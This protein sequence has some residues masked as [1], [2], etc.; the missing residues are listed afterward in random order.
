MPIFTSGRSGAYPTQ[1]I[2]TLTLEEIAEALTKEP[3]KHASLT[4]GWTG[5][6]SGA[7]GLG[8]ANVA[9]PKADMVILEAGEGYPRRLH[10]RYY[11]FKVDS[12]LKSEHGT[13][14]QKIIHKLDALDLFV[15]ETGDGSNKK[16]CLFSSANDD[17]MAPAY[18]SLDELVRSEDTAAQST[19]DSSPLTFGDPDVFLWLLTRRRDD[20]KFDDLVSLMKIDRI[21]GQ[22][23]HRRLTALSKGVDFDR[24]SFLVAVADVETLGPA[25]LRVRDLG[26]DS[27]LYFDLKVNGAFAVISSQTTYRNMLDSDRVR[28]TAVQDLAYR[29]LPL[30]R[31]TY[32]KDQEWRDTG[33]D[34]EFLKAAKA[35]IDLYTAKYGPRL[36]SLASAAEESL[37]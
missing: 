26:A 24:P 22:D 15:S 4:P 13:K 17:T 36:D 31:E 28:L 35:L 11:F 34:A 23:A 29:I 1:L 25:R 20:A 6:T 37:S 16:L 12:T 2:T 3:P 10:A 30:I 19:F 9:P 5:P 18:K 27:R 14:D 8:L 21:S 7:S 33:R 32:L